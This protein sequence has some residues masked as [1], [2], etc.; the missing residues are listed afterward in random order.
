MSTATFLDVSSPTKEVASDLTIWV[1][2]R[3]TK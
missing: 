1:I 3:P 2:S